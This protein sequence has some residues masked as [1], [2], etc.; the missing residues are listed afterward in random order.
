MMADGTRTEIWRRL[1]SGLPMDGLGLPT[2]NGKIDV[3][4]FV[5]PVDTFNVAISGH[6]TGLDLSGV[7]WPSLRFRNATITNCTIGH[8]LCRDWRIWGTRVEG[9]SFAHSDLQGAALGGIDEGRRNSYCDVDF[10]GADLRGTAHASADFVRCRFVGSRLR[11]VDFQGS[12]FVDT[13]FEG[14][15]REVL[16]YRHAFKGEGFPANEMRGVDLR[17]AVLEFAEFRGID[18]VDALLP[19]NKAHVVLSGLRDAVVRAIEVL[20][21]RSDEGARRLSSYLNEKLKWIPHGKPLGV[22]HLGEL[23]KV[24]DA[25]AVAAMLDAMKGWIV[26]PSE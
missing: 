17:R 14:S 15:L 18:L 10:T 6:W 11:G 4:G 7:K 26:S 5:P 1:T 12:V 22:M 8:G 21:S 19:N 9:C 23:R 3:R 24:G 20:S 25:A 16:F 2:V 13:L